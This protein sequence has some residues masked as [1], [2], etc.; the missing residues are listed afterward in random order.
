MKIMNHPHIKVYALYCFSFILVGMLIT[1]L[2]PLLP[3]FAAREDHS[4]T[5]YSF[6]FLSR[7]LGFIAGS[8]LIKI[9]EKWLNL[10]QLA[11]LSLLMNFFAIPFSFAS[12]PFMKGLFIFLFSVG[13]AWT[14]IAIN[15]AI[16]KMF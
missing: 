8:L 7:A 15:V 6:L 16:I 10:H 4:E 11:T 12:T 2:G 13:N 3:F 14:D 5:F 1:A 9:L